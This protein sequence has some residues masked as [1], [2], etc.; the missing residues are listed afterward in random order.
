MAL[1]VGRWSSNRDV[2]E[3]GSGHAGATN[4]MRVAGWAPALFVLLWDLG[5][6]FL[7]VTLATRV[8]PP[9]LAPVAAVAA[10]VGHCWPIFAGF[11][12]GMGVAT[13]GGALLAI[14]PLGFVLGVGLDAALTLVLRHA[15]RANILAGLSLWLLLLVFGA[16][17][18]AL[19]LAAGVGLVVAVR[20][21]RDWRRQYQELWLDRQG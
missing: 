7:V 15:A 20:S 10:V 4:V 5:K 13:S 12:G 16:E 14:W 1:L 2:R 11:Q 17:T 8:G 3:H 18:Q 19:Y 6:G 9:W 21:L